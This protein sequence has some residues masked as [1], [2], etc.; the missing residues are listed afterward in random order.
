MRKKTDPKSF[1][2]LAVEQVTPNMRNVSLGGPALST[3]PASQDGGYVKLIL[4]SGRLLSR[5][6]MRT[7]TIRRQTPERLDIEFALHGA[8]GEGG[9]AV[10]WAM[11]AQPG[12]EITVGGPG[13]AKPLEPG[14]D[15]Y[16][17][18]GDMTSLPAIAVNLAQ[19]P[20]DARG[21]VVVEVRS[22]RDRQPLEHPEGIRLHWVYNSEPG[23]NTD[24]FERKMRS[25]E[26]PDGHVYAW[27]ATEFEMMRRVRSYLRDERKLQKGQFYISSYWKKG[28]NED[29]H[30]KVKREDATANA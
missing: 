21:D 3:F 10:E 18:I 23:E 9:P 26:W 15:W 13:P 25:I 22:E 14:A 2:V 8:N 24:A 11:K 5:P 28:A 29:A 27:S 7:Y 30:K 6:L 19:L 12:D 4:S 20:E 16:F 17:I 1:T